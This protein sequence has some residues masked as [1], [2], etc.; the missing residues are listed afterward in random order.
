MYVL[1][2]KTFLL[3][4]KDK[5]TILSIISKKKRLVPENWGWIHRITTN[6]K[7]KTQTQT[8]YSLNFLK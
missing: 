7:K 1:Y 8:K 5:S 3:I 2:K 4:K 6:V